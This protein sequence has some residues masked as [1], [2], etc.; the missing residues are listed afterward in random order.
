MTKT[1]LSAISN[2]A[3]LPLAVLRAVFS[4][5][6]WGTTFGLPGYEAFVPHPVRIRTTSDPYYRG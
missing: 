4:A 3:L 5:L 1:M 2:L 6:Q